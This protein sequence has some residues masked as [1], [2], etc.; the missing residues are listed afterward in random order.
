M[1]LDMFATITISLCLVI[2]FILVRHE[3]RANKVI[4]SSYYYKKIL[5]LNQNT[6]LNFFTKQLKFHKMYK[7]KAALDKADLS[8]AA[9][10]YMS[11]NIEMVESLIPE[12]K[13][14]QKQY[15]NYKKE[16]DK[17]LATEL[18]YSKLKLNKL[19]FWSLNSFVKL[20]TSMVEKLIIEN[21]NKLTLYVYLDYTSPKGQS[22]HC[23]DYEYAFSG[24]LNFIKT[25]RQREEYMK[26][27][28]YQRSILS[29]SLRYDVLKRDNFTCQICG[30]SSKND[31]VKLEVDHIF[32]VSK[33]GKTEMNNL[34]TLCERCNR[35]K[36]D[37]Y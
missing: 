12:Y 32:P 30:A 26:S 15:T 2:I 18:D 4:N 28:K 25:V 1:D 16:V 23:R 6:E 21:K 24:I 22:Y 29:D 27:A 17:I 10:Q 33:G 19:F 5:K 36:S 9:I 8:A 14:C 37:K 13:D 20:E 34:Q 35:G 7:S 31:G 3:Y 11:E